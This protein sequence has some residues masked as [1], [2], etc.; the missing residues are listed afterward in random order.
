[1]VTAFTLEEAQAL[2]MILD[3]TWTPTG[4]YE[5]YRSAISKLRKIVE[6]PRKVGEAVNGQA[7][8]AAK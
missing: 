4:Y 3:R 8:E 1:M 6:E 2:L 7:R 5:E